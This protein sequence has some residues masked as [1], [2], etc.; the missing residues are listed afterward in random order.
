MYDQFYDL[1]DGFIDDEEVGIGCQD[2]LCND[3][4]KDGE[5]SVV[6]ESRKLERMQEGDEE[7]IKRQF[8]VYSPEEISKLMN[9]QPNDDDSWCQTAE[10]DMKVG[11]KRDREELA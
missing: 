3:L 4:I 1:D 11:K 5:Q 10:T 2:E 6:S 7:R 8:R 9:D